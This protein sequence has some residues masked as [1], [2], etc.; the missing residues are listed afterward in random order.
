MRIMRLQ[1]CVGYGSA[2]PKE[3]KCRFALLLYLGGL[4]FH[5]ASRMLGVSLVLVLN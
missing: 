5:P 2:D 1:S 3:R 4:G